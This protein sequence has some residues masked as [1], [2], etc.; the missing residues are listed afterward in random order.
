MKDSLSNDLKVKIKKSQARFKRVRDPEGPDFGTGE[1]FLLI[2]VTAIE[3]VVYIPI[4]IA[5]G[6]KPTGFVYQIEGTAPSEISTT[7]IDVGGVGVTQLTSGTIRYAKIPEGK[8]GTFR[9]LIIRMR[10][11]IGKEYAIILEKI[12]Y[13][14]NP[15]AVRYEK[16]SVGIRSRTREFK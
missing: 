10:G 2:D 5:S 11:K 8:T 4:S 1:F 3:G 13:K 7:D 6:K 12:N 16:L 14:R 9:I 15:N